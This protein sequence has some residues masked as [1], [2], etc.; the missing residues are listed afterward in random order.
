MRPTL[1]QSPKLSGFRTKH[2]KCTSGSRHPETGLQLQCRVGVIISRRQEIFINTHGYSNLSRVVLSIDRAHTSHQSIIDVGAA[3][4]LT[5]EKPYEWLDDAT[6]TI[7][8]LHQAASLDTRSTPQAHARSRAANRK[9]HFDF[10]V[11]ELEQSGPGTC[12]SAERGG[13]QGQA[14]RH[15]RKRPIQPHSFLAGF[16]NRTAPLTTSPTERGVAEIRLR[17][18]PHEK[19]LGREAEGGAHRIPVFDKEL[20]SGAIAA[21]RLVQFGIEMSNKRLAASQSSRDLPDTN[22][23]CKF[24][25]RT[26]RLEFVDDFRKIGV[27]RVVSSFDLCC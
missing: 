12:L 3:S 10:A 18:Q 9:L 4:S 13:T 6:K 14:K 11:N 2:L 8:H 7:Y 24:V 27:N 20:P 5:R 19:G 17:A 25:S 1:N 15:N 23:I 26:Q 22:C 21:S 16:I